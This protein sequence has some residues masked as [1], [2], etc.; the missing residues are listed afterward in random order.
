MKRRTTQ[1]Q[2]VREKTLIYCIIKHPLG[3]AVRNSTLH[4]QTQKE[5]EKLSIAYHPICQDP[6]SESLQEFWNIQP[7]T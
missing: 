6:A 7:L 5:S 3:Q 2:I 4:P 1:L